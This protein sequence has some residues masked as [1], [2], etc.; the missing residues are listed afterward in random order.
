MGIKTK[1]CIIAILYSSS[2]FSQNNLTQIKD[3]GD[4]AGNLKMYTYIPNNLNTNKSVPLVIAIHGC[5]QSA[6][7]IA[8]ET[9]WNKLADSLNFIVIYPE[10]KLINNIAK[11]YNFYLGYKAKKGKGEVASLKEMISYVRKNYNID[12][13]RI[14]ITGFSSGGAISNA[15]LNSYPKLFNAGALF[16]APSNLFNPNKD[17][18]ENQPKVVIIQGDKDK[19]VPKGNADRI[20]NQWIKKNEFVDT[21]YTFNRTYLGNSLLIAKHF[22]NTKQE[23]KIILIAGKGI[24][25]KIMISPGEAINHGG[26]LDYHSIDINFHSTY[27]VA[28]FFG[29]INK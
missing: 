11:C 23:L 18:P 24:K 9:G 14:S 8:S 29:L 26:K 25:H 22:Y 3:F 4:N 16:A 27:F 10:Q 28:N 15:M 17:S 12:S 20:L 13:S 7:M 6:K 19:I 21:N 1:L 2:L 5:T